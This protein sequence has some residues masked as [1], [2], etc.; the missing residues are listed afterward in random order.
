MS[1]DRMD[2]QM[3]WP[4]LFGGLDRE[5]RRA[6]VNAFAASWHEGWVPNREDVADLCDEA[7]GV[8]TQEEYLRQALAKATRRS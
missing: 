2:L 7:R 8:I 5:Q 6:I 1:G 4:E 3:W